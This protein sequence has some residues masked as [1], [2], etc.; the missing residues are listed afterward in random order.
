VLV[1]A[2]VLSQEIAGCL[3]QWARTRPTVLSWWARPDPL[4]NRLTPSLFL[5]FSP[6]FTLFNPPTPAKLVL[7]QARQPFPPF[8]RTPQ[9]AFFINNFFSSSIKK[10]SSYS[11]SPA[12]LSTGFLCFPTKTRRR[13]R[14]FS[15]ARQRSPVTPYSLLHNTTL[16]PTA[17]RCRQ[18]SRLGLLAITYTAL[19]P[20]YN[21]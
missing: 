8:F 1:V 13:D 2:G 9:T 15:Y 12:V 6:T 5:P 14:T 20:T 11:Q 4:T 16:A 19:N 3:E 10:F 7:L 21:P 18:D 17:L